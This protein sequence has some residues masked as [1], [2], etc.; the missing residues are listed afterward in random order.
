M[1]KL[2][3]TQLVLVLSWVT[4]I[5]IAT[6][7]Q[8]VRYTEKELA[9][10][11][12][13]TI[14]VKSFENRAPVTTKWNLGD[15]LADELIDRLMDT[16]RYTVLER[17]ELGQVFTEL[18]RTDDPRFRKSGSPQKGRLKHVRYLVKGVVTDFGHVETRDGLA[19]IF[20]IF[21]TASF[22]VVRAVIYVV[23]VPSGQVVASQAVEAKVK[24]TKDKDQVQLDGMAFG[25]YTFYRTSIGQATSK[26]LDKAV[27]AIAASIAEQDFQPKI[28]SILNNQIVLNGGKNR[29]IKVGNEYLVRPQS[30]TVIDPDTGDLLGHVAG[31]VLGRV[32]VVQVTEKFAF[33]EVI[34][35][36][37]F[38]VGQTLFPCE[39][40][41]KARPADSSS[42]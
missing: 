12:R 36:T 33:A 14:A 31:Q 32:R 11:I 8:D 34:T 6:G 41:T 9:R 28:A 7:C 13:P 22:S 21:G 17:S 30:K 37:G 18:K 4:F 5:L 27:H 2:P 1:K 19:R 29:M 10:Y 42:Y 24:D 39:A 16:R 15:G 26:M 35:G 3:P 23:D 38:A 20:D 40:E 25:S